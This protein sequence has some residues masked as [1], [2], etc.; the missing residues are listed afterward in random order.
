MNETRGD[1]ARPRLRPNKDV[2]AQRYGDEMVL[3]H[4][5]TDRIFSLNRT[6]ARLWELI[7]AGHGEAETKR[8]MMQEFDAS[9]AELAGAIEDLVA[10]LKD[11]GLLCTEG[12]S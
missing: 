1:A 5:E 10:S 12:A 6:G 7:S 8:R 4:L 9:E 11:E 3:I 2:V